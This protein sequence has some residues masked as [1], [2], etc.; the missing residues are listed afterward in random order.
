MTWL[1]R[2]FGLKQ[3]GRVMKGPDGKATHAA[4]KFGEGVVMMGRPD[5]KQ[6]YKNPK[7][8]GQATQSLYVMVKDLDRHFERARKMGA[9]TLEEPQDTE[10][11][12][13]RYGACDP[14]GH[15]WY[16]AQETRAR[17]RRRTG[18]VKR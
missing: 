11:G 16:F 8:L 2:A 18:R 17:R 15:E 6:H 3:Y 1:A 4:M 12:H 5:P 10:Y 14:E 9:R 13:R 7:R